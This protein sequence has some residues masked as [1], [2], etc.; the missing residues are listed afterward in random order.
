VQRQT[1][2]VARIGYLGS[3]QTGAFAS[4]VDALRAGLRDFGHVEGQNII[5]EFRW[6]ERVDQFP[7]LAAELVRMNVG[8]IFA[9]SSTEVEPARQATKTIP[10]VFATHADPVGIGHVA[11]LARPGGNITGLTMLL[12][13]LA[14]KE[15]EILKEAVPHV[16]RIGIL[17]NPT[18]PSHPP[19]LQA[20]KTAGEK[21]GVQLV[22]VPVRTVEDLDGASSTTHG[23]DSPIAVDDLHTTRPVS[24]PRRSSDGDGSA[25]RTPRDAGI[26]HRRHRATDPRIGRRNQ[27][28]LLVQRNVSAPE[29]TEK[30]GSSRNQAT[31]EDSCHERHFLPPITTPG[32]TSSILCSASA[33]TLVAPCG[34]LN[35]KASAFAG[36]S[37][38]H[39]LMRSVY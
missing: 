25:G 29:K 33:A 19:A 35:A 24:R 27:R 8:V 1:G 34:G 20:V 4:R 15:L 17:W 3:G 38:R 11:S 2:K 9:T 26:A 31:H 16:R 7:E 10:I 18:T 30:S 14:A 6:A 21:L 12:T 39:S 23:G 36:T 13:D 5:I 22:M 28:R 37:V 32:G